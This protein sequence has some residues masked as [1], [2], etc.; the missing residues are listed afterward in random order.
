MT[1]QRPAHPVLVEGFEIARTELTSAQDRAAGGPGTGDPSAP[2]VDIGWAEAGAA[3]RRAGGTLPTEAEWEY[4]AR[5]GTATPWSFGADAAPLGDFAWFRANS[6]DQ[7][8]P[9][10]EKL[11]NGLCLADMHGNVYEWVQDCFDP[12]AYRARG[13]LTIAPS[14]DKA[15]CRS[16]VV[17]G[18]SFD[19][20][21][22]FL[23]SAGRNGVEPE[24]RNFSLGLRCVRSR[25]RQR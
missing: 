3:C 8:H 16:R 17:R 25:A 22:D 4:A 5:A 9:V 12:D 23:R 6:N 2:L 20:P 19:D 10:G 7:A 15:D 11:P 13:R 21:P 14:L 18:G 1:W 24:N